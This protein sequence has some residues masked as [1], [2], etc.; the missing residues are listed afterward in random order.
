MSSVWCSPIPKK[1]IPTRSASTPSSTTSLI[2]CACETRRPLSSLVVSPNVF[3]PN[4]S[5]NPPAPC[6]VAIANASF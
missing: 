2:V 1:S 6:S 3:S 4:T 5:G